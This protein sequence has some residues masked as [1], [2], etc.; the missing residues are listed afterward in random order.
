MNDFSIL[1]V[2]LS[3]VAAK[4]VQTTR[5]KEYSEVCRHPLIELKDRIRPYPQFSDEDSFGQAYC[6][7]R[8]LRGA[9]FP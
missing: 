9:L 5:H 3:Q 8:R 2:D 1:E 4:L 7:R 6:V